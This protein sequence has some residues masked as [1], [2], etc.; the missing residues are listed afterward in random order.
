ML[1]KSDLGINQ[2][3]SE[4]LKKVMKFGRKSK[5]SAKLK[6]SWWKNHLVE[7]LVIWGFYQDFG[8]TGIFHKLFKK[9]Q[10]KHCHRKVLRWQ[11]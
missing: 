4:N 1:Q 5:N 10:T 7:K 8:N 9:N 6:K 2:Q 3:G 11:N